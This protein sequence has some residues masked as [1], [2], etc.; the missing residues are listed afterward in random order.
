MKMTALPL[1]VV[2]SPARP[3]SMP[4]DGRRRMTGA[5]IPGDGRMRFRTEDSRLRALERGGGDPLRYVLLWDHEVERTPEEEEAFIAG[6]GE[7]IRLRWLD[8]GA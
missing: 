6:G 7:I 4:S 8:E 2:L 5:I 1:P 3:G